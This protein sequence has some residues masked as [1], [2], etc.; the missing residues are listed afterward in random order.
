M[1]NEKLDP[2]VHLNGV[3]Q[4]VNLLCILVSDVYHRNEANILALNSLLMT[5][6]H[7]RLI[8]SPSGNL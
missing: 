2:R 7:L 4:V 6:F 5:N 3:S 1:R 8:G